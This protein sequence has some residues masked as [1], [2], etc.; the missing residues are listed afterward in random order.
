MALHMKQGS[1]FT[2]L[3]N[4]KCAVRSLNFQN[5]RFPRSVFDPE[6]LEGCGGL[7]ARDRAALIDGLGLGET[8][9]GKAPLLAEILR[10][11]KVASNSVSGPVRPVIERIYQ[12]ILTVAQFQRTSRHY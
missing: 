12:A 6:V 11:S 7:A 1:L 10:L 4:K 8:A 3:T 2:R 9:S 5:S